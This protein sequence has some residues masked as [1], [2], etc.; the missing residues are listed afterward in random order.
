MHSE[1]E[2]KPDDIESLVTIKEYMKTWANEIDKIEV[3]IK[4]WIRIYDILDDFN[5]KFDLHK[6]KKI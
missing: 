4:E 2:R 1:I 6:I 5:D 3:E